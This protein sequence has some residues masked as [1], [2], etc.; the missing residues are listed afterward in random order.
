MFVV[1][2]WGRECMNEGQSH[3]MKLQA[4]VISK[5][6]SRRKLSGNSVNQGD[7][8]GIKGMWAWRRDGE[9][10][11][12][13]KA[14]VWEWRGLLPAHTFSSWQPVCRNLC[15]LSATCLTFSKSHFK[16]AS[17]VSLKVH[18]GISDHTWR[19]LS[20]LSTQPAWWLLVTLCRGHA[21][22]KG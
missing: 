22:Y 12:L 16:Y 19:I 7:C 15:S 17:L 18:F 9:R 8:P 20:S 2:G 11:L 6:S 1:E 14:W 10:A 3:L 5:K 13:S 21:S 4:E